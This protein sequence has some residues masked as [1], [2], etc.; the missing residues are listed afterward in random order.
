MTEFLSK[1]ADLIGIL[2]MPLTYGFVGWFTNW[3]A[4][5]MTFYTIQEFQK[6]ELSSPQ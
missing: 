3:V 6:R 4:L 1:H 2:I 5:K